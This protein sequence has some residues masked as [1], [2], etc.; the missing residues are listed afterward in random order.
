MHQQY[1]K[2]KT[3]KILLICFTVCSVIYLALL[4]W[5]NQRVDV[6]DISGCETAGAEDMEYKIEKVSCMYDYIDIRGY[7]YQPGVSLLTADTELLAYDAASGLYY[8]LPTEQVK[9]PKLTKQADDG[10]NYDYAQFRSVTLQK[11][12]PDGSRICIWYKGNGAN[13]L[14]QTDEVIYY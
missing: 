11:K 5:I 7:A 10:C 9:K 8:R 12:I 14:I 13:T 4:Y 6:A 1:Q 3:G 2:A